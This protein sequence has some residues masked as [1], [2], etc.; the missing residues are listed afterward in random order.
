[1]EKAKSYS[2]MVISFC[3][4][5]YRKVVPDPNGTLVI[6]PGTQTVLKLPSYNILPVRAYI[7]ELREY[8]D[9]MEM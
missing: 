7:A 4:L 5:S 8:D 2:S 3:H 1:M 6:E 9:L